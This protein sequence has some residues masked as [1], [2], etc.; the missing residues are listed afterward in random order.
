MWR[1]L[2]GISTVLCCAAVAQAMAGAHYGDILCFDDKWGAL[3]TYDPATGQK[4]IVSGYGMGSQLVGDGPTWGVHIHEVVPK[5]QLAVGPDGAVYLRQGTDVFEIDP[6]TGNRRKYAIPNLHSTLMLPDPHDP[7]RF[8]YFAGNSNPPAKIYERRLYA[9]NRTTGKATQYPSQLDLPRKTYPTSI[10][11]LSGIWCTDMWGQTFFNGRRYVDGVP[12]YGE[13]PYIY[14]DLAL[15]FRQTV[16]M[17]GTNLSNLCDTHFH[18]PDHTLYLVG[19]STLAA[20]QAD[21]TG[22]YGPFTQVGRRDGPI[23]GF[24]GMTSAA[25]RLFGIWSQT[26]FDVDVAN[27]SRTALPPSAP[28]GAGLTPPPGARVVD[29]NN[30]LLAEE[31]QLV[32]QN[33]ASPARRTA[34]ADCAAGSRILG[35]TASAVYFLDDGVKRFTKPTGLTETLV[36]PDPGRTIRAAAVPDTSHVAWADADGLWMSDLTLGTRQNLYSASDVWDIQP[37]SHGDVYFRA[38]S[39]VLYRAGTDGQMEM[40]FSYASGIASFAHA[41]DENAI[42]FVPGQSWG[43]HVFDI[44]TGQI[45]MVSGADYGDFMSA[46][47]W[48]GTGPTWGGGPG[49]TA[50]TLLGVADGTAYVSDQFMQ[51]LFQ[52]DLDTGDRTLLSAPEYFPWVSLSGIVTYV[53]EPATLA[54]LAAGLGALVLRKRRT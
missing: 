51:G 23:S 13:G 29:P 50:I 26:V 32:W 11:I 24:K 33:V 15:P 37:G 36:P 53:P 14:T 49:D 21:A 19:E 16:S 8:Y 5:Q 22:H 17:P 12:Q 27:Q 40:L 54:L 46:D 52:V 42:L 43:L 34:P 10:L 9:M 25:G 1:R 44:D 41:Q 30:L 48:L 4:E 38:N 35:E 18:P 28:V 3:F 39:R 31:G 45:R 6:A 7:N 20:A 2:I 47:A